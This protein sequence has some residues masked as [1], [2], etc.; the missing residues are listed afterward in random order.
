MELPEASVVEQ[1][2]DPQ[3]TE[4]SAVR[5]CSFVTAGRLGVQQLGPQQLSAV[6]CSVPRTCNAVLSE[7]ARPSSRNGSSLVG[8][9]LIGFLSFPG[10]HRAIQTVSL[11]VLP[12]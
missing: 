2:L 10:S 8:M 12:L 5:F 1:Q 7:R 6:S 4:V 9:V 3:H 11:Y